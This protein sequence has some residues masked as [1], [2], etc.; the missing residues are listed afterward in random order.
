MS[1][2]SR[3]ATV[4]ACLIAA[5][6]T[7]ACAA[8]PNR[9]IA[10]AQSALKA[11]SAAGAEQFAPAAFKSAAESYRLANEAVMQE[12]YRLALSHA[13]ES[14][15]RAQAAEREA[16]AARDEIRD[17]AQRRMANVA[18]LLARAGTRLDQAEAERVPARI[19][20]DA[21]QTLARLNRDVQEADAVL[22]DEDYATAQR[23]LAAVERE[24]EALIA[25]L[26]E[27]LAAQSQKRKR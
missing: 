20:R 5:C 26:E 14:R 8:P 17:D 9:E 13:L 25:S 2:S 27:A 22:Q 21:R 3:G 19:V 24:L 16:A 1:R 10:D 7:S 6:L 23:V 15:E 18:T 4:G 11:A 12:D